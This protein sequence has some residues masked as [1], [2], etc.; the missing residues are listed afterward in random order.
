MKKILSTLVMCLIL[1]VGSVW[2][3]SVESTL[4]LTIKTTT[5]FNPTPATSTPT[6]LVCSDFNADDCSTSLDFLGTATK[7]EDFQSISS[8]GEFAEV[9]ATALMGKCYPEYSCYVKTMIDNEDYVFS[10]WT[11]YKGNVIEGLGQEG[12]YNFSYEIDMDEM[13]KGYLNWSP[14]G[15]KYTAIKNVSR[16]VTLTAHWIQPQVTGATATN[17]GEVTNPNVE[18]T[19]GKIVFSLNNDLAANNY[20]ANTEDFGPKNFRVRS[21][22]YTKGSYTYNIAYQPTGVHGTYSAQMTLSSNYPAGSYK[23][24]TATIQVVENYKPEFS[25]A[26]EFN[27]GDVPNNGGYRQTPEEFLSLV[28]NNYAS[29]NAVWTAWIEA[30]GVNQGLFVIQGTPDG[31]GKY[32]PSDG[33]PI[34]RFTPT[35]GLADGIYTANL[36]IKA[37]YTDSEPKAIDSDIKIVTLKA[38]SYTPDESRIQFG[39]PKITELDFGEVIMGTS[40]TKFTILLMEYI[41]ENETSPSFVWTN[42]EVFAYTYEAGNVTFSISPTVVCGDFTSTITVNALSSKDGMTIKTDAIDIKA[43]VRMAN[44]NLKVY[45]GIGKNTLVW[46]SVFGASHYVIKRND[47]VIYTTTDNVTTK[48]VD[49]FSEEGTYTYEVIAVYTANEA[50]N[51]S[52]TATITTGDPKIIV[53]ENVT[54]TGL[55]TGTEY[56]ASDGD[57][58]KNFPYRKKWSIDLSKTFDESGKALFDVLYIFGMTTNTEGGD[59]INLPGSLPCNAKTLCYVYKKSTDG[60]YYEYETKFD[61]VSSREHSDHGEGMNGKHLYFTGYC[62]FANIGVGKDD[63]GWMYFAGGNTGVDIY[64]DNCTIIGRYRTADGK[65]VGFVENIVELEAKQLGATKENK[66]YMKGF[67]SIF[68][69]KS[70]ANSNGESYKPTIHIN[71]ENHLKG[72]IGYISN[73]VGKVSSFTVET[74]IGNITTVSSPITIKPDATGGYTDL[75]MD[76]LWPTKADYSIKEATNGFLRLNTQEVAGSEKVPCV[77]LGSEFASLTINGGQYML[78]NSAADGTYTCNMAFSYRKFSK[79]AEKFGVMAYLSL[80]GF[81]GDQTDCRVVINGGTFNMYKNMY[82]NGTSYLGSNYYIDQDNFLDLRLPAGRSSRFSH[83]NGGTF[84]GISHVVFC[85]QVTSSGKSPINQIENV[86]CLQDVVI[87]NPESVRQK[88]GSIRFH[89]PE[90]FDEAYG[91]DQVEYD[92]STG[93]DAVE[94][95]ELYGGQSVNS[96]VK[97]INGEEKNVVSILLP[98]VMCEECPSC[99]LFDEAIYYNWVTAIPKFEINVEGQGVSVGGE[100]KVPTISGTTI[101]YVVNQLL[102]TDLE[103]MENATMTGD[104]EISFADKNYLR[105]Q[106][107][108]ADNY[109]IYKNLNTLKVVEADRWYCFVA[110]YDIHEISVIETAETQL[111]KDPYKKDRT[112]AK[113]LQAQNNLKMLYEL[114]NFILPDPNGRAT[115]LTLNELLPK[116]GLGMPGLERIPLKHYN[117]SDSKTGPDENYGANIFDA[118]YYLYE[119][120]DGG[121]SITEGGDLNINW[122]E[123]KRDANKPLMY[124]GEVYAIQFPWC[125]MCNDW[126]DR[127][128]YDYWTGKLILFYGHGYDYDGTENDGQLIYGIDHQ[129]STIL[130]MNPGEGTAMYSGNYTLADMTAPTNAY[131]HDYDVD[132]EIL[133]DLGKDAADWFIQAPSGHTVKPTEGFMLYNSGAKPMPAR[134]SRSGQIE[135]DENVNTGLPTIAGRTSLM[136]FGAYDGFEVLS[137]SEQLV[138][139][140]N[141]QGN[142]IFQQYMAEGEQVYVA[143]GA[144]VFIVRGESETIK[145]M[146][147]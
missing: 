21:S 81:G 108:N 147:E 39:S 10:H 41:T 62:P 109:R 124:Q 9:L 107:T 140:Y 130:K 25:A 5:D 66:N 75:T 73:V 115:S 68:V 84:N 111:S 30:E 126:V 119:I 13:F 36:C 132:K 2:A 144:G 54:T 72:Q 92:L 15:I 79:V 88:N 90:P 8:L 74:G 129:T 134:I 122:V 16:S 125:P 145:V 127:T 31:E 142:I 120:P 46:E 101:K 43:K 82:Q 24:R 113:A 58:Y 112:A 89:V 29:E 12:V 40:K 76:D 98:Q 49:E 52:S 133:D 105:G 141:L 14:F 85:S 60:T 3:A 100:A 64:L 146:V 97:K 22:K 6:T 77:D 57:D 45:G 137:L 110:P 104:I 143:T 44:P 20:T 51:T 78:R 56:D 70:S 18:P 35:P 123:V 94:M 26:N 33:E 50:Y 114:S 135:Y 37:T 63:E 139:V 116:G 87:E 138:T 71:G 106:F 11:D 42:N 131:V 61:A 80:Y 55:E 23:S 7:A 69:F 32:H 91:G 1:G 118:N 47:G 34:I 4:K 19:D 27:F 103:G 48:Y 95:N 99:E 67:S 59:I 121:L 65:N 117:G 38:N 128:D 136:L 93:L 17:C 53:P 86:L 28:N 102:Y 96:Y 83:I